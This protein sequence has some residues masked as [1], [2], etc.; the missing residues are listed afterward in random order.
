M[1]K[2]RADWKYE[3]GGVVEVKGIKYLIMKNVKALYGKND[4][5]MSIEIQM[6]NSCTIGF[7]TTQPNQEVKRKPVILQKVLIPIFS[8]KFSDEQI[9]TFGIDGFCS[10]DKGI[11][12]IHAE[13]ANLK[14][15]PKNVLMSEKFY[16][17]FWN[18]ST[19]MQLAATIDTP[20][21]PISPQQWG[22]IKRDHPRKYRQLQKSC[23]K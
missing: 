4:D 6:N 12:E 9:Y 3:I 15:L 10:Y 11:H 19:G 1:I 2:I 13:L 18:R 16:C 22:A 17:I 14:E 7:K 23:G 21:N 5:G 8:A 20:T